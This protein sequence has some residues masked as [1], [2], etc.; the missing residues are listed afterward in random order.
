MIGKLSQAYSVFCLGIIILFC[1]HLHYSYH[2]F[3]NINVFHHE[4][5]YYAFIP[6][7]NIVSGQENHPI[8]GAYIIERII[9]KYWADI[10]IRHS[11]EFC[12]DGIVSE[13]AYFDKDSFR[14]HPLW[15]AVIQCFI[16]GELET[17]NINKIIF[18]I[19]SWRSKAKIFTE[20]YYSN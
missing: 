12:I 15:L 13:L 10:C 20:S 4:N 11:R 2:I 19:S 18:F 17:R 8:Y 16:S 1:T 14:F 9:G 3:K 6:M 5:G 7:K